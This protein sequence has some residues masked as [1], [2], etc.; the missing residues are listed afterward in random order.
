MRKRF[1]ITL[2]FAALTST[3][4]A[5]LPKSFN[6]VVPPLAREQK[7]DLFRLA[8]KPGVRGDFYRLRV[9]EQFLKQGNTT[10]ALRYTLK[11]HDPLLEFWK[12]V[13]LSEIDVANS[14]FQEVLVRL[15]K[16]PA[17]PIP[18]ISFG[19]GLYDNVFQR[20]LIARYLAT[21]G[22]G[23]NAEHEAAELV[24]RYPLDK[25]VLDLISEDDKNPKLTDLQKLNKL[26]E[27]HER[28]KYKDIPGWISYNEVANAKVN[29]ATKCQAYYEWANAHRIKKENLDLAAKAL[30]WVERKCNDYWQA[31]A[32]FR[33]GRFSS[34]I[35]AHK[36]V[37]ALEKLAENFPDHRLA[38]DAY[39]HLWKDFKKIGNEKLEKKYFDKLMSRKKGDMKS[40]L[41]FQMAQSHIKKKQ[42]D[43]AAKILKKGLDSEPSGDESYPRLLY[44]YAKSIEPS[45]SK[46]AK[47]EFEKLI[48]KF[49]FSFYAILASQKIN[50]PLKYQDLPKMKGER[51]E[52]SEDY[53]IAID[54]LNKDDQHQAA[55]VILDFLMHDK[56]QYE[57]TNKVYLTQKLM[58]SRNYRKALDL[59]VKHFNTTFYGPLEGAYDDPMFAAFFPQVFE[60]E[61]NKGYKRNK[62]PRGA[63]EGI[64]REESLYQTTAKSWVGATGLMQLMPGTAQMVMRKM[65]AEDEM[66]PDLTDPHNNIMLGSTYL[67]DM[68]D[69]FLDQ[70]PLAIMAY[71][72]GPGNVNKWLRRFG[73]MPLDDFIENVPYD[74]TRNYVKRVLRSMVVYGS[75]FDEPYFTKGEF[76]SFNIERKQHQIKK[77][78]RRRRR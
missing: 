3:A 1:I 57:A 29:K 70:L 55:R 66:T 34:N 8:K 48:E 45:S 16:L 69:Y 5:S 12:N 67:R 2:V 41:L 11:V 60:A 21:K 7:K 75:I 42:F 43:K 20:A 59:A 63:I 65:T 76:L 61:V 54:Q 19:E 27:L 17:D 31:K 53:F 58:E 71:N 73:N 30:L 50:K 37:E 49:P 46:K 44:W 40:I 38:D 14:K 13:V 72:A 51:P 23:K 18:H 4:W 47:K 64:M 32:L 62:L 25:S 56:P 36:P 26:H 77:V 9:A 52:D 74:E 24:S 6:D 78:R 68:K 35:S 10:K 28:Y 33:L 22:L 39:Y 15:K